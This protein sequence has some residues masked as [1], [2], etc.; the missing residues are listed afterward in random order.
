MTHWDRLWKVGV[1]MD[2][3]VEKLGRIGDGGDGG[4]VWEFAKV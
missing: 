4:I 3:G 2:E 1:K